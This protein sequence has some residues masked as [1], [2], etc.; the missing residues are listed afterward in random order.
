METLARHN[1]PLIMSQCGSKGSAINI[2]QVGGVF[3][4]GRGWT[5]AVVVCQRVTGAC[6][7]INR[8]A[9]LHTH[10]SV[11]SEQQL[12]VS[13]QTKASSPVTLC[14]VCTPSD[15]TPIPGAWLLSAC[16]PPSDGCV[17]GAAE[18]GRQALLQRIQGAN[19]ATFPTW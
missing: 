7:A 10:R 9:I 12:P 19:T 11:C 17:C 5:T 8:V 14:V 15:P 6:S 4:W 3:R 18:C 13:T 1:S 2:A 16:V